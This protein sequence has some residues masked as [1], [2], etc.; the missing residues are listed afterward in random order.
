MEYFLKSDILYEDDAILVVR[1]RAQVAVQSA[2]SGQMDLEHALLNYLA[3]KQTAGKR[4][5]P[6]L[7]VIH[8]LDQPVEGILV[9]GKTQKA[10]AALNRQL[11]GDQMKKRYL[12]VVEWKDTEQEGCLR[13]EQQL[14]DELYK[15]GRS[16]TSRVVQKGYPG[17]KQAVLS[18]QILEVCQEE[19][20]ALAAITLKTGRHHQIRVQMAHAGM[21][22]CGDKKYNPGA[23]PEDGLALCAAELVFSHPISGKKLCFQTEPENPIFSRFNQI[24]I[25]S[26][27]N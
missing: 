23:Q 26:S 3:G 17:A 6:Y 15:D 24:I 1:K 4:Q 20:R 9:F 22:L 14:V 11:T 16:N 2:R 25:K 8:R 7:A 19:G 18:F 12:A 5:M 21:P 13:Q 10:A 27:Q